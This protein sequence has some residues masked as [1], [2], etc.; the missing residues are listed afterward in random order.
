MSHLSKP[1]TLCRGPLNA[2]RLCLERGGQLRH[3]KCLGFNSNTLRA[4]VVAAKFLQLYSPVCS[5][6]RLTFSYARYCKWCALISECFQLLYCM[7]SRG[8][9]V[10][11]RA[12][13]PI[14]TLSPF[15]TRAQSRQNGAGGV[16]HYIAYALRVFKCS[17]SEIYALYL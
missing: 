3:F 7:G 16:R 14:F 1:A 17:L 12:F 4:K 9:Y 13:P 6:R 11:L 10:R 15:T 5:A 8:S 2:L